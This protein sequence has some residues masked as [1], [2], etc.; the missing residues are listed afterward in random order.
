MPPTDDIGEAVESILK[1]FSEH[2]EEASN[3]FWDWYVIGG[4]W[5]GTKLMAHYDKDKIDEFYVWLKSQKITVSGLQCG[6]QELSPADQIPMVDAKWTEMFPPKDGIA[7]PCPLFHHSN[8]AY[9]GVCGELPDDV[10]TLAEMPKELTSSRVIIAGPS[11]DSDTKERTGPPR[12]EF[13]TSRNIWNGVD[14]VETKWD[15]K[16]TSALEQFKETLERYTE[17]HQ[18]RMTPQDNWLVVTVDYHS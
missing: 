1:P 9:G 17:E 2:N 14:F 5:A 15:G 6:K 7:V 18:R 10:C 12:A 11:Y 3:T 16:I 13:M 4:R 8:D